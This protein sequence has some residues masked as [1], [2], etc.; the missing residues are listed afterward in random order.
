MNGTLLEFFHTD[1]WALKIQENSCKSV[2]FFFY[3]ANPLNPLPDGFMISMGKVESEN[4]DSL[5]HQISDHR[6]T[7]TGRARRFVTFA[8]LGAALAGGKKASGKR[9]A[10]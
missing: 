3:F 4:V 1:F 10:R 2:T 9:T 8:D 7:A 5:C 6:F